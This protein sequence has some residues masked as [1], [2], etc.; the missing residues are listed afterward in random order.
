MSV[1]L[2]WLFCFSLLFV[3]LIDFACVLRWLVR[4]LFNFKGVVID[5]VGNWIGCVL[6]VLML[7][8]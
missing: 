8:Y 2:C 6:I 7:T 1:L 5:L 3:C 4:E